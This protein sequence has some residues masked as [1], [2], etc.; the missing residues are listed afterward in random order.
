MMKTSDFSRILRSVVLYLR[1]ERVLVE[2]KLKALLT[3]AAFGLLALGLLLFALAMLNIA[4]FQ[5]LQKVSDPVWTAL[6]MAAADALLA[7][8]CLWMASRNVRKAEIL[9]VEDVRNQVA[10]VLEE[11]IQQLTRNSIL[12]SAVFGALEAQTLKWLVPF[13]VNLLKATRSHPE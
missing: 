11:E 5:A 13:F 1:T 6:Y 2:V 7:A 8:G 3:R 10:L 9:V 12:S 4:A